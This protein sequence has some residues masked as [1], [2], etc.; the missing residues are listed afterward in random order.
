MPAIRDARPEPAQFWFGP[1]AWF[2]LGSL[3]RG[4]GGA[5]NQNQ[6]MILQSVPIPSDLVGGENISCTDETLCSAFGI[7]VFLFTGIISFS[8]VSFLT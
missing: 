6:T 3:V 2:R 1:Y 8:P 4:G 7:K 5:R